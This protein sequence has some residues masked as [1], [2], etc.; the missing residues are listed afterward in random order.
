MRCTLLL[1]MCLSA[2]GPA[3][4]AQ[5]QDDGSATRA[6]CFAFCQKHA[7]ERGLQTGGQI[8][9]CAYRCFKNRTW[10]KM[11][12][13]D[14]GSAFASAGIDPRCV[15]MR[16]PI[17][18]TCA[19]NNGGGIDRIRGGWYSAVGKPPN[20]GGTFNEKFVQCMVRAGRK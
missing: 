2:L 18:C 9:V 15:K 5:A 14:A 8:S 1:A 13:S 17:G 19:V 16:D 10:R 6:A 11:R 7:A 4:P 12:T 20:H 3:M